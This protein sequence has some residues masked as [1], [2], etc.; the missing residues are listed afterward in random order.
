L[1]RI[2]GVNDGTLFDWFKYGM[3]TANDDAHRRRRS[4]FSRAF[5]ARTISGL[6]PGIR[7][8]DEMV[9][10]WHADG[11]AEFVEIVAVCA[12]AMTLEFRIPVDFTPVRSP[13]QSSVAE[14]SM[15]RL[16]RASARISM[17]SIG[18]IPRRVAGN[19]QEGYN[20]WAFA[21]GSL[22]TVRESV[23]YHRIAPMCRR[24]ILLR[25]KG[26]NEVS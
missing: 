3:I 13:F 19:L 10:G 6:R 15:S 24:S 20:P 16:P 4:P 5:A 1:Q 21:V 26:F 18:K 25:L 17:E 14:R 23:R 12:I 11:R 9:D 2:R 22:D 7:A 8:A